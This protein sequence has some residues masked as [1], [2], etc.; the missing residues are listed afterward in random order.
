LLF[1]PPC[2]GLRGNVRTLPRA[3]WK[4]RVEF[5]F[6]RIELFP[7]LLQMRRYKR[8]SIEVGVF[9]KVVGHSERK[10]QTEGGVTHQPLVRYQKTRVIALCELLNYPQCIVWF[11][12]TAHVRKTDRQIYRR[13]DGH[14]ELRQL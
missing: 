12:H 14:S 11:Y 5:L 3:R 10:F 9:R 13:T 6:V 7:Y 2:G 1:E 4:V 8:K